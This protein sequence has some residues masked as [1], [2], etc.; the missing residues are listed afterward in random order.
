M[1]NWLR[2]PFIE[3]GSANSLHIEMRFT[4]RRCV[5]HL[6][7]GSLQQCKETFNLY[8]FEADSD[9]ANELMPTWDSTAYEYKGKIAAEVLYETSSEVRINTELRTISLDRGLGGVYFAFQDTGAC[10]AL[11]SIK[12]SY[13]ACPNVTM[14]YARFPETPTGSKAHDLKEEEGVCVANS[15]LNATPTYLCRSDGTWFYPQGG[16]ECA[17]GYVGRNG[18]ECVGK[19]N[20]D[21]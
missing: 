3:R 4:M 19:T 12:V 5:R 10:V 2:T 18:K 14:N 20:V 7:P 9:F 17:A 16:C 21:V 15:V 6:D 8:Y 1:D 11:I 13:I